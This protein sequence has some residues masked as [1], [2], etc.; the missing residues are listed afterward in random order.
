MEDAPVS[1][2][3][4]GLWMCP[5]FIRG[6]ASNGGDPF[7]FGGLPPGE[8]VAS[9]GRGDR[10][11]WGGKLSPIFR[12]GFRLAEQVE[13]S[14]GPASAS[15]RDNLGQPS[16]ELA[17]A[18]RL[19]IGSDVSLRAFFCYSDL[20]PDATQASEDIYWIQSP[21]QSIPLASDLGMCPTFTRGPASNGGDS[22]PCGELPHGEGVTSFG[23]G[24]G[25][26]GGGHRQSS[27]EGFALVMGDGGGVGGGGGHGGEP[28]F[29]LA[30]GLALGA[31]AWVPAQSIGLWL[32]PPPIG[33]PFNDAWIPHRSPFGGI[34]GGA[35]LVDFA[36]T[37]ARRRTRSLAASSFHPDKDTVVFMTWPARAGVIH[38]MAASSLRRGEG[39]PRRCAEH[40]RGR[41]RDM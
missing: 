16:Q 14:P 15:W 12:G 34:P 4:F 39:L 18:S 11:D 8:G 38:W 10:P 32:V 36:P 35:G 26:R 22:F 5:T 2:L 7:P 37:P 40:L 20:P 17:S 21:S 27:G 6:P 29:S 30:S 31:T 9:F 25:P 13:G 41:S 23:R 28:T 24:I 1:P 3:A 33:E 19:K